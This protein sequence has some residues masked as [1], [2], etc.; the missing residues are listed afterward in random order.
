VLRPIAIAVLVLGSTPAGTHSFDRQSGERVVC[1]RLLP[2]AALA[3]DAGSG[4]VLRA[5]DEPKPDE[6]QCTWETDGQTPRRLSV[7]YTNVGANRVRDLF[8]DQTLKLTVAGVPI[9]NVP[10][11]GAV[12]LLAT[13]GESFLI[14]ARNAEAIITV[15]ST[16]L[17][18]AQVIAVSRRVAETPAATIAEARAALAKVRGQP[19]RPFEPLPPLP[20]IVVRRDG[21]PLECERLLPKAEIVAVLGDAYRLTDAN[22][23][24]PGFSYCEWKRPTDDYTF[25]L[26]VHAEPEFIDAKVKGPEGFFAL[27]VSLS[28]CQHNPGEPLKGIGE[29][30][31]LCSSGGTYFNIIVRR[32]KD[33]LALSCFTC[34]RDQMIALARA[35]LK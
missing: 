18:R 11:V 3:S 24:R 29:Q 33:V 35:A 9:E 6:W 8:G 27:E 13:L 21:Q 17:G 5:F 2:A 1:D 10:N 31:V 25:A 34:S 32:V 23:P 4:F 20:D 14:T 22:D 15:T 26:R 7:R 12:G 28:P 30:A 19:E 16:G